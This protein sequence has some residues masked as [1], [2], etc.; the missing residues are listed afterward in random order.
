MHT[1]SGTGPPFPRVLPSLGL[2]DKAQ[3]QLCSHLHG[4]ELRASKGSK[5]GLPKI[6]S[7]FPKIKGTIL[8]IPIIRT[9]VRILGKPHEE[10]YMGSS[11]KC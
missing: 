8:E 3:G 9:R 1:A 11:L 2:G 10:L 4:C 7:G 6:I 5:N